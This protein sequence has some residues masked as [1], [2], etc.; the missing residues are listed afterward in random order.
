MKKILVLLMTLVLSACTTYWKHPQG[1]D[2]NTDLQQCKQSTLRNAC[3]SSNASSTTNCSP[4]GLGGSTCS[5]TVVPAR[6]WC[7]MEEDTNARDYCLQRL[8]W[9]ETDKDGKYK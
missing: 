4:N 5:T 7:Q 3:Y 8:G 6:N 2:W 9:R 1:R